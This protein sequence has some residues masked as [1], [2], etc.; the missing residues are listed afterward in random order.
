M[1]LI[2]SQ[3]IPLNTS[4]SRYHCLNRETGFSIS[5]DVCGDDGDDGRG[6]GNLSRFQ[7]SLDVDPV[8]RIDS[9]ASTAHISSLPYAFYV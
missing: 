6:D 8:H 1:S 7:H 4:S 3:H 5:N 9:P 2:P